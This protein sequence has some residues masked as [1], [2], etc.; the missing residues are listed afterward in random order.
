M[1]AQFKEVAYMAYSEDGVGEHTSQ[2]EC[3]HAVSVV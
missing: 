3:F 1:E 2:L